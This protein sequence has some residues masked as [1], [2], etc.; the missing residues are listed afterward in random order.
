MSNV[1]TVFKVKIYPHPSK[2][3]NGIKEENLEVPGYGN[4]AASLADKYYKEQGVK[5]TKVLVG[6]N[7]DEKF[8]KADLTSPYDKPT[9]K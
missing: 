8:V 1:K 4:E 5:S 7:I 3:K 9:R 2:R 6:F